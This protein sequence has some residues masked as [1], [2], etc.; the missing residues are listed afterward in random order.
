[1]NA[2]E[3]YAAKKKLAARLGAG[4]GAGVGSLMGPVGAA[5]GGAIG[6]SRGHG[7][8]AAIGG[9]LGSTLGTGFLL[10]GGPSGIP[11]YMATSG[12][13]AALIHGGNRSLK[14]INKAQA[15]LKPIING[16]N[17][18]GLGRFK[19][20]NRRT[21]AKA[22]KMNEMLEKIKRNIG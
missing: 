16:E 8:R 2:L 11:A 3:K 7:G 9:A 21:R 13:G 18:K 14:A 6:A 10:G 15:Q 1:M 5:A 4:I 22:I 19:A 20:S 12:L 17:V